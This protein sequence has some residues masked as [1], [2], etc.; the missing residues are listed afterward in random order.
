[1]YLRSAREKYVYLT[2]FQA[3][4]HQCNDVTNRTISNKYD[5]CTIFFIIRN[6]CDI[7][8]RL[9]ALP[10]H[11]NPKIAGNYTAL[12]TSFKP[13]SNDRILL[14]TS[15][16][17]QRRVYSK[18]KRR[19]PKSLSVRF[20]RLQ[21]TL[22]SSR[23]TIEETTHSLTDLNTITSF[24]SYATDRVNSLFPHRTIYSLF[25]QAKV[26]SREALLMPFLF[27]PLLAVP[28]S[29]ATLTD[30]P[31]NRTQGVQSHYQCA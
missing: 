2:D 8:N 1:M 21:Q 7:A 13:H 12:R 6:K 23:D 5:T 9:N 30:D 26:V 31:G 22:P 27:Y 15:L 11:C 20:L 16:T 10:L 29:L 24:K 14:K 4:Q 19:S 18:T 25:M 17:E 3:T 28:S